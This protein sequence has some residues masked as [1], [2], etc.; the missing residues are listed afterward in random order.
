MVI[1]PKKVDVDR[2]SQI[3]ISNKNTD[4]EY[5]IL[6]RKNR[7][8][9]ETKFWHYPGLNL[10]ASSSSQFWWYLLHIVNKSYF[11]PDL[12]LLN[13]V[14]GGNTIQYQ[15]VD[16]LTGQYED[17]VYCNGELFPFCSSCSCLSRARSTLANVGE[18]RIEVEAMDEGPR[19]W[20]PFS[21]T[22]ISHTRHQMRTKLH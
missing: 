7:L 20:Y 15:N 18:S 4:P 6:F 2:V 9:T 1:C 21:I 17:S 14:H 8:V 22:N 13:P 12:S 3:F 5:W 16:V 19:R 11:K 10:L